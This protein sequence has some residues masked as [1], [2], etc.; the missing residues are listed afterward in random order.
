MLYI[1]QEK[2]R[3][4]IS[5]FNMGGSKLFSHPSYV[6]T[7]LPAPQKRCIKEVERLMFEYVWDGKKDRI[8]RMTLKSKYK[9]GGL[10]VPDLA[11]QAQSLKIKWIKR[12]LDKDN[13]AKWKGL[14]KLMLS[15]I[16]DVSLFH[17]NTN[18]KIINR[19][20]RNTFWEE[21]CIAWGHIN[22]TNENQAEFFL[23]N[24]LWANKD[25][26]IERNTPGDS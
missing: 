6:M 15:L 10:K 25:L 18:A 19:M 4:H 21:T 12:Y 9:H 13:D 3:G 24:A 20:V 5:S 7:V 26:N 14:A 8:K 16:N 17:Y 1:S 22:Q 2:N 11:L 23:D